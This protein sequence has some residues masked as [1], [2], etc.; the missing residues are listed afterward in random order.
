METAQ[1]QKKISAQFADPT[2]AS[3]LRKLLTEVANRAG[4]HPDNVQLG[5]GTSFVYN[6]MEQVPYM[7]T[8]AWT[9]AR[10][11]GLESEIESILKMVES[12]WIEDDD[13]IP[14]NLGIIGLLDDAY[15]SL[16]SMQTMSDLY[17]MQT[18]KHLF[19]DDLRAANMIMKKII[20]EPFISQLDEIVTRAVADA[21]VKEAVQLLSR[22]DK[23]E[24]LDSQATIWNH[25]P[26]SELPV[27][28][29]VGLG[30]TDD[31]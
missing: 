4:E 26:V 31:L 1:I 12:Y 10:T 11:V 22:P 28:H 30:L 3:D 8:V 9:S 7:L 13:V 18:G 24:L 6:Y 5:H 25:G 14:D 16:S 29:L 27:S 21:G 23:Q 15:C 19:P 17:R 20:G 2:S